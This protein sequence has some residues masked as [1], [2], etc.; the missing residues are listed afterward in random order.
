MDSSMKG[1]LSFIF[2]NSSVLH[3]LTREELIAKAYSS[4]MEKFATPRK[5]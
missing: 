4:A 2:D 5:D 1:V 3:S